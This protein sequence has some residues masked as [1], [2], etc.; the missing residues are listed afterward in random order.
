MD[1]TRAPHIEI[2]PFALSIFSPS[3]VHPTLSLSKG[4]KELLQ[5][6]DDKDADKLSPTR[7][8]TCCTSTDLLQLPAE[9]NGSNR[10][11]VE[12]AITQVLKIFVCK[13]QLNISSTVGVAN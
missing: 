11:A 13:H 2:K 5:E 12:K 1:P 9:H 10:T 8:T 7:T 4:N 3:T 6:D